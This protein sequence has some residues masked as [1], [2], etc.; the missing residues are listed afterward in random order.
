MSLPTGTIPADST[1]TQSQEAR[2]RASVRENHQK[3]MQDQQ[4]QQQI[5]SMATRQQNESL[6]SVG[7][8][9]AGVNNLNKSPEATNFIRD[10]IPAL[11]A[12]VDMHQQ[13]PFPDL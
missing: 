12:Q 10:L 7:S 4:Q 6:F 13:T 8:T 5:K 3:L 11:A 2:Q 9:A 1:R